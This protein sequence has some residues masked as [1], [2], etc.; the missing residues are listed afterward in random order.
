MNKILQR[1]KKS[2]LIEMLQLR[3]SKISRLI[4]TINEKD[5]EI[6]ER[7]LFDDRQIKAMTLAIEYCRKNVDYYRDDFLEFIDLINCLGAVLIRAK[8]SA[9]RDESFVVPAPNFFA[10]TPA[11]LFAPPPPPLNT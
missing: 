6:E 11:N 1:K 8:R 10:S 7:F 9:G 2:E 4:Q 3:E 5:I